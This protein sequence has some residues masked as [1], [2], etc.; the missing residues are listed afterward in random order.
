MQF[1]HEYNSN[2]DYKIEIIYYKI[3][4]V[5]LT[6]LNM[7]ISQFEEFFSLFNSLTLF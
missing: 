5:K 7:D 3:I 2:L 4:M 1:M 6:V